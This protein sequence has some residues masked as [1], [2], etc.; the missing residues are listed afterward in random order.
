MAAKDKFILGQAGHPIV[1][2]LR[3]QP[4]AALDKFFGHRQFAGRTSPFFIFINSRPIT[5][6]VSGK[7]SLATAV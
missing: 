5:S 2:V 7:V 6:K 3:A 4:D 1:V